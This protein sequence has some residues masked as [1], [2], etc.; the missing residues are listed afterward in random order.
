MSGHGRGARRGIALLAA[1]ALA[2]LTATALATHGSS[3]LDG[4]TTVD[5]TL[6]PRTK[7][8]GNGYT[9]LAA[10]GRGEPYIVRGGPA[11]PTG[12]STRRRSLAYFSQMTD[13]Q[14][15]DEESPA[16]VE[17]LDFGPSSAWRPQEGFTPFQIE[18]TIRQINNFAAASPVPQGDGTGNA[19]DFALLT[20]DQ[21][22]NQHLNETVWVRDL[23][24]GN[25]PLTFNSGLSRPEDYAPEKLATLGPDCAAFVAS[26]GGAAGA[27]AEGGRYT[28]VQDYDDY[29]SGD[30]P[31]KPLFY[32]PDEP[33]GPDWVNWPTYNGLM[34]RA[35]QIPVDP[36]GL[37]VPFYITNGNHDVLVQGNED[38]LQPIEDIATGCFKALGT[39]SDP[40][41]QPAPPDGPDPSFLLSPTDVG[42]LVP[43]DP[44]RQFVSKPQ[45]KQV[46]GATNEGLGDDDHGF[47]YV[48]ESENTESGGSASYYAWDPPQTPGLRFISIDT[49]SEGGQTAETLVPGQPSTPGSSNGNLDDPQFQWL[50]R[51]LTA[52]RSRDQVVILFGHHPVRSMNTQVRDEQAAACSTD[53]EHGHDQNPGCDR[54][55]RP[56]DDDP[57]T[58]GFGCL[59]NGTD[60]QNTTCPGGAAQ[61]ESFVELIDQFPNVAGYVPGHTHEHRLTP[62]KRTD[63]TT[64]WEINTSA[65]IDPPN[66][67]RLIDL[68]DNRDGTLSFFNTVV[69]HAAPA[70]APPACTEPGCAAAFGE[71]ELASIGRTFAFNDPDNDNSGLGRAQDRNAELLLEDPRPVAD[72]SVV[73]SDAPDPVRVGDR[74]TYTLTV[75][76][77]GPSRAQ[78][79]ALTDELPEQVTLR[80][81]QLSQGTCTRSG[82]TL[83]CAL[84]T[85]GPGATASVAV[86]VVPGEEGQLSN[87]AVVR[88]NV[89]DRVADND[90]ATATTEVLPAPDEEASTP[91]ATQTQPG[92]ET[93][94]GTSDE[95]GAGGGPAAGAPCASAPLLSSARVRLRG[96]RVGILLRPPDGARVQVDIFKSSVGRRVVGKRLVARFTDVR[97]D[98]TWNG[99]ANRRG[100][101]VG[102][103]IYFVR[104]SAR[105]A[106][107]ARDVRRV[108]LRRQDGRWSLRPR[109]ARRPSC[110]LL[111]KFKLGRPVFGGRSNR[112][113]RVA[114][115]L[116][117]DAQV[118]LELL[119]GTRVIARRGPTTRR[120]GVTHR[121]RFNA[122]RRLRG[123]VRVRLVAERDGERLRRVLV[124][125]RL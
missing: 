121:L 39:T 89:S 88:G 81:V 33:A 29:P 85:L 11:A 118:T 124:S 23:L 1:G 94:P 68:M 47:A 16:R 70:A 6:V 30:H 110:G 103:G 84:G 80:A 111:T 32:D 10:S 49:N 50:K 31:A 19:M 96:T 44:G 36:E 21:A 86:R 104:F 48:D 14:L 17:F 37:A 7:P 119:R 112:A 52:A 66:Q 28:G 69:D 117:E 40:T 67:S 113:L 46:Y 101:S 79:V 91:P 61:H 115:R 9:N 100:R 12:R 105:G 55:L 38:A 92:S 15:A 34:D 43:P 45:I 24:E 18:Q 93:Q 95:P 102:D 72:L 77:A 83:E 13:F 2:A 99:M 54:D 122:P 125:R 73:Q 56:S 123:D 58:P 120:G 8:A 27:A 53:D 63:G 75:R 107:G 26:K 41:K 87:R 20:G 5:R 82:R 25:G 35:Q 106:N 90:A 42:M 3:D 76:N 114:F 4:H 62:F 108:V 74:L 57:D 64:W 60:A 51:E 78:S 98:F 97:G 22:D 59:H 109:F 116:A 71:P 65:V